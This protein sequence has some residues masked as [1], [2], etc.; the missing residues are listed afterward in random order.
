[1]N[2]DKI[3]FIFHSSWEAVSQSAIN[4]IAT[5]LPNSIIDALGGAISRRDLRPNDLQM[6]G[7]LPPEKLAQ[8]LEVVY[9]PDRPTALGRLRQLLQQFFP[10][11]QGRGD[12]DDFDSLC[13]NLLNNLNNIL[14]QFK[15]YSSSNP[16][17]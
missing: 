5:F 13:E 17:H 16:G 1:L 8:I 6:L 11:F 3:Y 4:D 12:D 7:Q 15:P 14:T 10:K 9:I 2:T